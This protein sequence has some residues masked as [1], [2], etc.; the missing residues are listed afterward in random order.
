MNQN[1]TFAP[2]FPAPPCSQPSG[3]ASGLLAA[4]ER[5]PALIFKVLAFVFAGLLLAPPHSHGR[6]FSIFQRG[7]LAAW[8]IVPFDSK[9][10]GPVERAEMLNRLGITK[11]A[12]DWRAEHIPT[13]DAEVEAMKARGIEISAWWVPATMDGT[14][15]RIF[16]VIERHKI[17]PQL[18]IL[19][20]DPAASEQAAKVKAVAKQIR[21][22]AEEALRHGCKLALYNHGGWFGE[23]DNQIAIINELKMPNVGIVYNFHHGHAHIDDFKA[24]FGRMKPHLM[25]LNLNGM[26]KNG[27]KILP[28]G[29]G[30]QEQQMIEV[31]LDSGWKGPVGILCHLMEDAE[32][33]LDGNLKGLANLLEKLK[34]DTFWDAEDP[35]ARAELPEFKVLPAGK[36]EDFTLATDTE[37]PGSANDWMRSH[38]D[39]GSTRFSQ[40]AQIHTQNVGNLKPVWTYHS[41]DGTANIQCNPVIVNGVIYAPTAGGYL[42]AIDG[43]TGVEKW[44][45][46]PD[47]RPAHRGLTYW[48]NPAGGGDRL[49]F[50]AGDFFHALDPLTGQAVAG[51]GKNGKIRSGASV[52]APVVYQN[53]IAFAGFD[54]NVYGFDLKSGSKLWT[55]HTVPQR[56]QEGAETWSKPGNG[57]NCW[58]GM[59]LDQERG[60]AYVTTGSPKPNFVGI[61]HRGDNL[62]ANCLIAIDMKTGKRLWH[63]QEIRHDIWDLDIPAPPNL[64]TV[65]RDGRRI[66]AVAAVTKIGNTLLLDRVSGELLHPFRL[67]RAPVSK[68]PGERTSPYQPDVELPEPFTKRDFSLDDVTDRTPAATAFVRQQ[69]ARANM[70]WFEPFEEARP[71]ALFGI[72]GGAEWTGAAVDPQA[73]RLYVNANH[74]PWIITVYRSDE[75]PLKPGEPL[76][77]GAEIYNM[78]CMACHGPNKEGLGVSPPLAGLRHRMNE[79][80]IIGILATGRNLMPPA[81]PMPDADR[82][83]LLDFLLVRDRPITP[84][85]E[86][87]PP[88]FNYNGYPRLN[89]QDG[90]PGSKPP[91]GTLN[92]IDLESGRIIWRV[93]LGEHPELAKQGITGTGTENFGGAMVTAGGLVFCAGTKDEMIRAFDAATGKELWKAKLPWGGYAPPATYQ[94]DGRQY[95]VIAATGGGKLGGPMGDAYVA[96]ALDD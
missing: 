60:I 6:D 26:I 67:R 38:G 19:V 82:R 22:M 84:E 94:I 81:P 17:H 73:G 65:T 56:G 49:L 41:K 11:L 57:A 96:F 79:Q 39:H 59:S 78:Y 85:V 80:E 70:G 10:R 58:G 9:Q 52:V 95:V 42:V 92:C 63:F 48:K 30:T 32:L 55:F 27:K 61:H 68:L 40:L 89:D 21:P 28:V 33:I 62:Y 53:I 2:S 24:L 54:R 83:A 13:F 50:S 36:P 1:T 18:W 74:V 8:C 69:L 3:P 93:P 7:N 87:A 76:T 86:N 16:E 64:V 45:F 25:A 91:W 71:T 72:H 12:Y 47:G 66:A 51:F 77:R 34:P 31:V 14:S 90:Y 4:P 37:I 75:L 43:R 46:K 20:P 15:R 35:E 5:F 44:R 29:A 23:P 88:R